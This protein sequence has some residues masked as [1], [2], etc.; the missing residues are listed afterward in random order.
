MLF[1]RRDIMRKQNTCMQIKI[2]SELKAKAEKMAEQ[3][4]K[5]LS[6]FVRYLIETEYKFR[7]GK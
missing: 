7:A 6:E 2:G 4:N 5:T 3:D 1:E